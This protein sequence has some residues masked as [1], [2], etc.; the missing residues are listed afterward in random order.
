MATY[1]DEINEFEIRTT[2]LAWVCY[3]KFKLKTK[4]NTTILSCTTPSS[5]SVEPLLHFAPFIILRFPSNV[6]D[7]QAPDAHSVFPA[8][9]QP[10]VH[11][12][13]RHKRPSSWSGIPTAY[14]VQLTSRLSV[15][16]FY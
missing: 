2:T 12:W 16:E 7:F 8:A 3:T 9:G 5:D 10:F 1:I 4:S 14:I 11:A 13:K 6:Q 15:L